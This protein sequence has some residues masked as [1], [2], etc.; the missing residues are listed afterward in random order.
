L[1]QAIQF[2]SWRPR[3]RSGSTTVVVH[4]SPSLE[5]DASSEVA[6][7]SGMAR[8]PRT[9]AIQTPCTRSYAIAGSET[10]VSET[11]DGSGRTPDVHVRPSCDVAKP[12]P[13]A[14]PVALRPTWKTATTVSPN[15]K[16]SG[17]TAVECC[18]AGSVNGSFEI[19]CGGGT[20]PAADP[21][22]T[23]ATSSDP[24]TRLTP[25]KF[26]RPTGPAGRQVITSS[27]RPIRSAA[28]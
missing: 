24:R 26:A 7:P 8:P 11:P 6:K 23:A 1:S 12:I 25:S 2:L 14:P 4:V 16:L 18:A 22:R 3:P 5:R 27:Y 20:A 17:S 9:E 21:A 19:C 13:D 28:P 15:E 10:N